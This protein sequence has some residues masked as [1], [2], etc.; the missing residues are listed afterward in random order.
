MWRPKSEEMPIVPNEHCKLVSVS[1]TAVVSEMDLF[2]ILPRP[3]DNDRIG[4]T[5]FT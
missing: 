5:I 4:K 2:R 1:G 3:Y